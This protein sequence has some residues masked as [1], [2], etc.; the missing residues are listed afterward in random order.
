[1]TAAAAVLIIA[2]ACL[3]FSV[4][5]RQQAFRQARADVR[6]NRVK[7]RKARHARWIMARMWITGW[8]LLVVGA[9]LVAAVMVTR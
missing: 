8:T 3:V 5:T 4:G 1:M 7:L 6:D 2:G 9:L